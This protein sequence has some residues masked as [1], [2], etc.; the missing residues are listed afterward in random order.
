MA[1]AQQALRSRIGLLLDKEVAVIKMVLSNR[2]AKVVDEEHCA[3]LNVGG[4]NASSSDATA[5]N[6]SQPTASVDDNRLSTVILVCGV[7]LLGALFGSHSS[8]SGNNILATIQSAQRDVHVGSMCRCGSQKVAM[9]DMNKELMSIYQQVPKHSAYGKRGG[10][11]NTH[12][13]QSPSKATGGYTKRFIHY[14]IEGC[15]CFD[16]DGRIHASPTSD[17]FL[18]IISRD[19][20]LRPANQC[21]GSE[22]KSMFNWDQM[23][24]FGVEDL[25]IF[26]GVLSFKSPLT[27]NNTLHNWLKHDLFHRI[28][29]Q[30]VMV[31]LNHRSQEDDAILHDFQKKLNN[32]HPMTMLGSEEENLHP[33]LAISKFC[34]KAEEHPSSHPNGENLV[35]FL[36]K[37][38]VI[39]DNSG[40]LFYLESIFRSAIALSQRGVPY[41]SLRPNAVRDGS[42]TWNCPAEGIGWG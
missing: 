23:P 18:S 6:R 14:P 27:L 5:P 26:V 9:P 15:K 12:V 21:T 31:Q 17:Q 10:G 29:A 32:R 30:D 22:A 8:S 1:C 33:G 39:P 34:R 38:W 13:I 40:K 37:D 24:D 42:K 41:I 20:F 25:P 35:L 28:A 7:F 2:H 11:Q 16:G 36:E 3:L 19:Y 4:Q